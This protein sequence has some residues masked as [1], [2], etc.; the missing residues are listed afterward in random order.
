MSKIFW[1]DY[2]IKRFYNNIFSKYGYDQEYYHIDDLYDDQVSK[3]LNSISNFQH[4][5]WVKSL[6]VTS[7]HRGSTWL[8]Y[9]DG[10]IPTHLMVWLRDKLQIKNST[11]IFDNP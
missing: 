10:L 2:N 5:S 6:R 11:Y 8:V 7:N 1:F 3:L 9:P 4:K